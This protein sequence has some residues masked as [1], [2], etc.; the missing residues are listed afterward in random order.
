M[1]YNWDK[2][3]LL[4][5]KNKSIEKLLNNDYRDNKEKS[6]LEYNVCCVEEMICDMK[7]DS[8]IDKN[9]FFLLFT[10]NKIKLENFYEGIDLYSTEFQ[11]NFIKKIYDVHETHPIYCD[12]KILKGYLP[13]KDQLE[14]CYKLYSF[15]INGRK[16]CNTIFDPTKHNLR[17]CKDRKNSF[18]PIGDRGLISVR[19][20]NDIY[21]F[22]SLAHEL[23]HS[24]EFLI[25]KKRNCIF[26]DAYTHYSEM[27]S[28]FFEHLAADL[29]R[30]ENLITENERLDIMRNLYEINFEDIEDFIFLLISRGE[31]LTLREKFYVKNMDTLPIANSQYFYSYVIAINMYKKYLSDPEKA[32]YLM[33]YLNNNFEAEKEEQILEYCDIDL[34]NETLIKHLNNIKKRNN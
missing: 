12:G 26:N 9:R 15:D 13:F 30:K 21:T 33:Q 1:K 34:S 24:Y 8:K 20:N 32:L 6:E 11:R 10:S 29:L 19:Q 18:Y 25:D 5:F 2:N 4:S 23:G 27:Y 16:M 31:K 17:F 22:L 3:E 7:K 14:L 28:L